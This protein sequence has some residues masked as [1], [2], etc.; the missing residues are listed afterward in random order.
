MPNLF[1]INLRV[2]SSTSTSDTKLHT[3]KGRNCWDDY[4]QQANVKLAIHHT[5]GNRW[6]TIRPHIR[7]Y[8]RTISRSCTETASRSDNTFEDSTETS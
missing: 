3:R 6:F 4:A 2:L 8:L 1:L 5:T 7:Y